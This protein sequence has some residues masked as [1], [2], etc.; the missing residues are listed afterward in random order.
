M[1]QV[2]PLV[3]EMEGEVGKGP[4]PAMVIYVIICHTSSPATVIYVISM[5]KIDQDINSR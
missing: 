5:S 1:E 4:S 2:D 3:Q